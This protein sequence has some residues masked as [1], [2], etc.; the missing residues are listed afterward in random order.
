VDRE[1]PV[2]FSDIRL[3]FELDTDAG[4]EE[5]ATLTKLTERYCVVWQTLRQSPQGGVT[6]TA[7]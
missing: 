2:G 7:A 5:L 6:M 1:V 4:A 3:H